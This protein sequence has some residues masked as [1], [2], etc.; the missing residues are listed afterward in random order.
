MRAVLSAGALLLVLQTSIA[1][2][3]ALPTPASLEKKII[4]YGWDVPDAAYVREH[5]REMEARPFDGI[6]FRLRKGSNALQPTAWA[7]ADYAEDLQQCEQ[8]AWEKFTDNFLILL[9]A[10]DQD[11]FNDEH[12]SAI[13]HNVGITARAAKLAKCVGLCFDAE[14]YGTNPW[15][16]KNTAHHDTKTFEEYQ[17]I[18]RRRG[19][20]FIQAIE[21]EFPHPHLLSFYQ[22]G[23]FSRLCQPMAPEERMSKLS[24]HDYAL[25]PAFFNGML[26]ASTPETRFTDGNEN[27]YYYTSSEPYFEAVHRIAHRARYLVDPAL[28]LRYQQ[29]VPAGQALYIDQYYGLRAIKV[30]GNYLTP[31]EQP[32]WFEHNVYW[33][34]YT[35]DKYVWC[36]S[37]RMNWW[38]N[39]DV[40]KG[41]E[42]AIRSAHEKIN[43]GKP[44]GIDI[45]PFIAAGQAR[46]KG[47]TK[48]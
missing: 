10:S 27:A 9:A 41:A 29:Q 34:L 14:P 21:K 32:K 35:T 17:D 44:L 5:I 25:F 36:Y 2:A 18:A 31:E 16:Y 30:L 1:N 47:E 48:Q 7:D 8:I 6:I 13:E 45:A 38:S 40:P 23:L 43:A 39:K 20:Q 37:E 15:S 24:E 11:W 12:W 4:E 33:A 46:E 42:E 3:D 22:L 19:Q 26:E 28:W